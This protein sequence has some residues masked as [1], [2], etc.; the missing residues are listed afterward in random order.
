MVAAA[1]VVI[2]D[3]GVEGAG[4]VDDAGD[5]V[6]FTV[7]AAA[8][9]GCIGVGRVEGVIGVAVAAVGGRIGVE[10]GVGRRCL[11]SVGSVLVLLE[12]R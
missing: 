4:G 3:V 9:G 6:G 5:V 2:G 10:E 8:V 7:S 12:G 11:V 1:G